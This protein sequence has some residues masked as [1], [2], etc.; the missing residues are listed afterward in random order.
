MNY[1]RA[2]DGL[3]GVAI[4][5]VILFHYNFILG[6]GW[7]GVQLF[8]VLSGYLITTILVKEKDNP[9]GFYLK[10]FYWRRTL[11]IFPLYYAYLIFIGLVFLVL[12]IPEDYLS[13]LP[14]LATYTFNFYPLVKMYSYEDIFFTHFWSLSVEEQFYLVWPLVVFIF[15]RKQLQIILIA[16]IVLSPLV[17]LSL[18][19][20]MSINTNLPNYY[21]GQTVY[22]FTLGQWD[23]F[24]F[25]ALIPVFNLSIKKIA[26]G[27]LL[28]A[29]FILVVCAGLVNGYSLSQAGLQVPFSS[30]GYP[31]AETANYQHVWSY[32]LLNLVF[33]L[34]IIH[35]TNTTSTTHKSIRILLEN[36]F[37]VYIGRIS[38]G[39]YVYHWLVWMAFGKYLQGVFPSDWIGLPVY[40]GVCIAIASVS[41]YVLEKPILSFKDQYFKSLSPS[42]RASIQT[43]ENDQKLKH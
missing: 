2:L 9:L 4:L 29:A 10:R 42:S 36:N 21:V 19:E 8:F 27:R 14:F 35:I 40:F 17:R 13:T 31:I 30:M 43:I 34:V 25:G 16:I 24:A 20:L 7:A 12:H 33:V 5:M 28:L 6:I 15:I 41:Y 38:Y 32:T 3:R 22:R 1:S 26:S 11:R 37:M 39:L 23:G 18:A